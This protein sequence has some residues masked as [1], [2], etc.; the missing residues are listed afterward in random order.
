MTVLVSNFVKGNHPETDTCGQQKELEPFYWFG[1]SC[2]N[3][4]HLESLTLFTRD[5]AYV[6]FVLISLNM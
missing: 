1:S 6:Y 2:R 3:C 5:D 4:N